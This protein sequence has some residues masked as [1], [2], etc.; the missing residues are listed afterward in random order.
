MKKQ[1]KKL[2]IGKETLLPLESR[3]LREIAGGQTLTAIVHIDTPTFNTK[4]AHVVAATTA[5]TKYC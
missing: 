1:V 3:Q 5:T 4:M 2:R